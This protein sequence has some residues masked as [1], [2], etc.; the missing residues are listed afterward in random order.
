MKAV[1][2]KLFSPKKLKNLREK[3][4]ILEDDFV[5]GWVG[6]LTEQMEIEETFDVFEELLKKNPKKVKILIVGDGN[7]K[8]KLIKRAIKK[9]YIDLVYFIGFVPYEKVPYYISEMDV[10]P[11]IHHDPHGGSIIREAMS[12]GKVALTV[13][14]DSGT[15]REFITHMKDGLLVSSENR[16]QKAANLIVWLIENKQE[17]IRIGNNA[18][19][20]ILK[21]FSFMN[22]TRIV[23]Q[24]LISYNKC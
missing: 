15:Q 4:G 21:E 6:R 7:L 19:K 16:I 5:I 18:R 12:C 23:E 11:L 1:D 13:D 2:Y 17:R 24:E 9:K 3:I 10:V 22:L 8:A 14:G 20:K